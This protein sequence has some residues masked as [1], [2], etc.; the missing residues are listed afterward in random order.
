MPSKHGN[1]SVPIVQFYKIVPDSV[2][3]MRADKS[4]LSTLP[5]QAYQHCEAIRVA[6][7]L[8]WYI[9][10]P[11]SA[12]LSFDGREVLIR[13]DGSCRAIHSEFIGDD[14]SEI[15]QNNCP[16]AYRNQEIAWLEVLSVPGTLQIWSGYFVS[17]SP[18]WQ[19]WIKPLTNIASTSAFTSYEGIVRT[20][21]FQPA[22]LFS[23]FRIEK[24]DRD[25][26]IDQFQPLFQVVPIPVSVTQTPPDPSF[27]DAFDAAGGFDWD[28][29]GRTTRHDSEATT[30]GRY[31]A[32]IRKRDKKNINQD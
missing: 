23:N 3:P 19:L 26:V 15:W 29:Y 28:G 17:T 18:G 30:R 8:G 31:G 2:D 22:P 16:P 5:L 7:G 14:F 10:P 13:E 32:D 27:I 21:V 4:A 9:F 6:S 1:D 20:D 24:T 25:L 11:K 12:L